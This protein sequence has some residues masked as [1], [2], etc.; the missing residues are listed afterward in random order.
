MLPKFLVLIFA[1]ARR[2]FKSKG[3]LV[4][5]LLSKGSLPFFEKVNKDKYESTSIDLFFIYFLSITFFSRE[6]TFSFWTFPLWM[7]SYEIME[8]MSHSDVATISYLFFIAWL[9]ALF[10]APIPEKA[11]KTLILLFVCVCVLNK[12]L[13]FDT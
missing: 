3:S 6:N 13:S 1:K 11:S 9:K 2:I 10:C 4:N 8:F 5:F 7:Q 12:T